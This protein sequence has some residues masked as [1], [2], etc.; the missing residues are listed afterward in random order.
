MLEIKG[1]TAGYGHAVVLHEVTMTVPEGK[2]VVLT[3]PNGHGKT[4]LLRALSGLLPVA[5]GEITFEGERIDGRSAANI[6]GRGL[7]HIPQGDLLFV[8]LTVEQNLFMGAF[9]KQAWK[10][11]YERI[12]RVYE[13]FPKLEERRAQQSRTLSGGERRMLSLGRGLMSSAKLLMVDEPGL[14]LAPVLVQELYATLEKIGRSEATV[15]IVEETLNNARDI[16][17]Y[18]Y[19]LDTG[20]IVH[21]G[22]MAE[23]GEEV[24]KVTYLGKQGSAP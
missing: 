9:L 3:G 16:A 7:V 19:L 21:G 5:Q 10:G 22:T 13:L 18:V 2:V 14:G 1:V 15:L 11:R 8:D 12:K 17:D 6:V 4:T 20:R 23:L 24:L